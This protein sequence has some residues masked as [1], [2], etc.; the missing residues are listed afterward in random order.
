MATATLLSATFIQEK[1]GCR[2][3]SFDRKPL[4][5]SSRR[6]A[7]PLHFHN[8]HELAGRTCSRRDWIALSLPIA[9]APCSNVCAAESA[10]FKEELKMEDLYHDSRGKRVMSNLLL[11][12]F[13]GV[14]LAYLG[15]LKTSTSSL[16]FLG[17][18]VFGLLFLREKQANAANV[19]AMEDVQLRIQKAET[20]LSSQTRSS[21]IYKLEESLLA[22]GSE[23]HFSSQ[24][25][26]QC[27][28]FSKP[29]RNR[30]E[31]EVQ[32]MEENLQLTA[33]AIGKLKFATKDQQ[34]ASQKLIEENVATESSL[35]LLTTKVQ[36]LQAEFES[37]KY[38]LCSSD[39]TA[40]FLSK[41]L[42]VAATRNTMLEVKLIEILGS[43]QHEGV[44]NERVF[45]DQNELLLF[46]G[47]RAD[48]VAAE[49][50]SQQDELKNKF[51]MTNQLISE[52]GVLDKVLREKRS[53]LD[54]VWLT[55]CSNLE[56]LRILQIEVATL[57]QELQQEQRRNVTLQSACKDDTVSAE[58]LKVSA[59]LGSQVNKEKKLVERLEIELHVSYGTLLLLRR[60][61]L[62]LQDRMQT[63]LSSEVQL[64]G[65]LM[66]LRNLQQDH[67][68]ALKKEKRAGAYA[69]KQLTVTRK[70]LME[71]S[72]VVEELQKELENLKKLIEDPKLKIASR[73]DQLEK[74][75]NSVACLA[76]DIL[77]LRS[78]LQEEK[79]HKII[80]SG[81]DET[82]SSLAKPSRRRGS[83]KLALPKSRRNLG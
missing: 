69:R 45:K 3:S 14:L 40:G 28:L 34:Q 31:V 48:V 25:A 9:W 39:S 80:S 67:G 70:V 81:I 7:D 22:N 33:G 44:S 16:G 56:R 42:T 52:Q 66:T 79:T 29:S 5:S 13:S 64:Q 26:G 50:V 57:N 47:K 60:E 83:P 17:C 38:S 4:P 72:Q 54:N 63:R 43:L 73:A 23:S 20:E 1:Q 11:G 15:G 32:N 62:K 61:V 30:L 68:Q 46:N 77:A 65:E 36:G 58:L 37:L 12:E 41:E 27:Q 21:I 18:L 53:T 6:I 59:E 82:P 35:E 71:E 19:I 74:A 24:E 75:T 10:P 8:N 76:D 2:Q 49:L 51:T 78:L 55:L